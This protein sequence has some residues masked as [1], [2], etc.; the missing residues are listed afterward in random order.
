MKTLVII[1]NLG[2]YIGTFV[3]KFLTKEI[4]LILLTLSRP[5]LTQF[6]H[7]ALK[8]LKTTLTL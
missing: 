5:D 6:I 3:L 2:D 4:I 1:S 7:R 8:I